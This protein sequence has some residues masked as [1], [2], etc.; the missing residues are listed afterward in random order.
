M[1]KLIIS[2]YFVG[3][4]LLTFLVAKAVGTYKSGDVEIRYRKLSKD[5]SDV[6]ME[7]YN[8]RKLF[9]KE[10]VYKHG[11]EFVRYDEVKETRIKKGFGWETKI[12]TLKTY[13]L[14]EDCGCN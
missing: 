9:E 11:F 10:M 3:M 2:G 8:R 13:I 12:D 1:K 14:Q 7:D 4:F 5:V 6:E